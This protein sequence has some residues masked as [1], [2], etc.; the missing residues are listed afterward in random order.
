MLHKFKTILT[1]CLLLAVVVVAAG[2]SAE[3]SPYE[4][5]DAQNFTVSVKFDANGGTFT[6][7]TSVIVDSFNVSDM[8]VD[9]TGNVQIPLIAPDSDYRGNDAFTAI[10]SGYFLAGWYASR[11][12]TLDENGNS[13]YVYQD[14]WDFDTSRLTVDPKKTYTSSEPVLTLYAAWVPMFEI[15]IHDLATG[16]YLQSMTFDPTITDEIA[17]PAWNTETGTVEM[18]SFPQR[19]GYTFNG[20]FYD[21]EG[22]QPVDAAVK[23]TGIVDYTNGMAKN[24]VMKLYVDWLEGEWFHIYNVDQFLENASVSGNYVI[25]EDLDFTDKVWPSNIMYG[26]F[27]GTIQGNGHTFKN[28]SLTQNNNSKVNAGLFGH[29][30]DEA[31]LTDITFEN[32]SF[33]IKSG[34]RVAGASFGLFAGAVSEKAELKQ[35]AI[36]NSTIQIH[37]SCYFGTDDYAIGLVCGMGS[38]DIDHS[39]ITCTAT[40]ENPENVAITVNGNVVTVEF[41]TP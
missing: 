38:T 18:H 39:G 34:T 40:G 3:E 32:V 5:N 11:T 12:Q 14:K 4:I 24:H 7:N 37:S 19:S 10:N 33:T 1:V 8:P 35:I 13:I 2:C 9:G 26:N 27:T 28:I 15:Q 22:K 41:A 20:A 6:T 16:S 29:L 17:V 30:T 23:H 36:Q 21:A 25:H 31:S